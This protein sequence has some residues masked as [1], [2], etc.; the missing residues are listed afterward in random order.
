MTSTDVTQTGLVE[1]SANAVTATGTSGNLQAMQ[2]LLIECI[3]MLRDLHNG[4]PTKEL[5][6][7]LDAIEARA[8]SLGVTHPNDDVYVT[9]MFSTGQQETLPIRGIAHHAFANS[10]DVDTAVIFD[11]RRGNRDSVRLTG[12]AW[13]TLLQRLPEVLDKISVERGESTHSSMEDALRAVVDW[14]NYTFVHC[15]QPFYSDWS[16]AAD[17]ECPVCGKDISP[18]DD[19]VEVFRKLEEEEDGRFTIFIAD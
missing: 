7:S 6:T 1:A 17:E 13:R 9:L 11:D 5:H 8:K 10:R 16:C 15:G 19:E 12:D 4:W 18:L 2:T 3:T 14:A